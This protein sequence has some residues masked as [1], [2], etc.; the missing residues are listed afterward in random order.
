L[1][2]VGGKRIRLA[3]MV[4]HP[5]Q[6]F[7]PWYAE[8]ARL[9]TLELKVFFYANWGISGLT[10][11]DFG[12]PL[13]WDV[14]LLDG[15]SYEFLAAEPETTVIND[16][17]LD[18]PTVEARLHDFSPDVVMVFGYSHKTTKRVAQWTERRSKPLL[19][20]T[21]SN[22]QAQPLW[23]L[24]L[25]K[26]FISPFYRKVDGALYVGDNN[27]DY[28][29]FYGLPDERLFAGCLPIDRKRL[30]ST[31]PDKERT[32][33]QIR[34]QYGIP[35]DA[36]V[37]LFC[38]KFI[39]R[40]RPFDVVQAVSGAESIW[41]LMVGDGELRPAIADYIRRHHVENVT[42]TGFVNQAAI[43]A[44]YA[45]ADALVVSSSFDPHPLI[46]TEAAAF[47]LPVIVSDEVGCVGQHDTARPDINARVYPCADVGALRRNLDSLRGDP[48]TY[49]RYSAASLDIAND[50]DTASA[51]RQ[52]E[53]AVVQLLR[54]GKR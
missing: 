19:L 43:P 48:T 32:R 46:V 10:D 30:I 18:N 23:K 49:Q 21:D 41:A 7:A 40:K 27:Y 34:E 51:A 5:I 44:Y 14:P 42:L 12:T 1:A 39:D 53:A 36:F 24:L 38:G 52:L 8:A 22:I 31:V 28:H 15:Y 4:S 6:H 17:R 13:T 20:Y 2:K 3:I 45:A 35:H 47:G 25:K 33:N 50:Q 9:S 16:P 37:V 11:P 29:R 26:A 54:L